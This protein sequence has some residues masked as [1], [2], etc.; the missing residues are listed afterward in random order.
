MIFINDSPK[1]TGHHIVENDVVSDTHE[2][3]VPVMPNE[4]L[5]ISTI[6]SRIHGHRHSISELAHTANQ[7]SFINR[8]NVDILNEI[9]VWIAAGGWWA[10]QPR[11]P[12]D[13]AWAH[14]L[15]YM[16]E[17]CTWWRIHVQSSP[18][19]CA[20]IVPT[21]PQSFY[22]AL[23]RAAQARLHLKL[24][25]VTDDEY[26]HGLLLDVARETDRIQDFAL[27][28]DRTTVARDLRVFTNAAPALRTLTLVVRL[29]PADL[30]LQGVLYPKFFRG[31]APHLDYVNFRN[32]SF[33]WT[34]SL[35]GPPM[36]TLFIH[37]DR[38]NGRQ[39]DFAM[40]VFALRRMPN[41][42][43]VMLFQAIPRPGAT[44]LDVLPIITM[45]RLRHLSMTGRGQATSALL[46]VLVPDTNRGVHVRHVGAPGAVAAA[47]AWFR[48]MA[49]HPVHLDAYIA[50][51]EHAVA[52]H[53][54]HPTTTLAGDPSV[55]P[56]APMSSL[57]ASC[58]EPVIASYEDLLC[59]GHSCFQVN[60]SNVHELVPDIFALAGEV[61][62]G[63]TD[64][65]ISLGKSLTHLKTFWLAFPAVAT[66]R[67]T[68]CSHADYLSSLRIATVENR[69]GPVDQLRPL[70]HLRLLALHGV[71]W[72][73]KFMDG[74][75]APRLVDLLPV[76]SE[77]QQMGLQ[78]DLLELGNRGDLEPRDVHGL[79]GS[80][81]K[82]VIV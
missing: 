60:G 39:T 82:V 53:L 14:P 68:T 77:R 63:I 70:R 19:Y 61:L 73:M 55:T 23:S 11:N 78:L 16:G 34:S 1:H 26:P 27:I 4:V 58:G 6:H 33:S 29:S 37:A 75:D 9:M 72:R 38:Y 31:D 67:I 40:F 7:Q 17:V 13:R 47:E 80:V 54:P 51:S 5:S 20:Y 44:N 48:H 45:P 64:L 10:A 15:K 36:R 30:N 57:Y 25:E 22:T 32:I 12:Y 79:E 21:T 81:G 49:T 35:L 50:L 8:L 41:L 18:L 46:R 2:P 69:A 76:L 59:P 62:A 74:F 65:R 42:E 24:I 66:L 52:I 3:S 71:C 28:G 43:N 56:D